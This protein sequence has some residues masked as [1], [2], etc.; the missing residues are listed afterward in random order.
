[1]AAPPANLPAGRMHASALPPGPVRG[2]C[3]SRWTDAEQECCLREPAALEGDLGC[4]PRARLC[5]PGP[6]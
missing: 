2:E 4:K 3:A 6:Q 1:M 5:R